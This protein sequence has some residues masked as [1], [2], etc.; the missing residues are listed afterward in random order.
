[1]TSG[2]L[3]TAPAGRIIDFDEAELRRPPFQSDWYLWVRGRLPA[4]GL[5]ARLA[6]RL[7]QGRPDYWAIEVAA[8]TATNPDNDNSTSIEDYIFERSVPLAGIT[9][10]RGIMVIGANRSQQIEISDGAF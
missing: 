7:Y 1:M 3:S 9:G 5:D 8:I 4:L 2:S 10:T 6:P